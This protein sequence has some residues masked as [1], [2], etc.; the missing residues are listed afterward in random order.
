MNRPLIVSGVSSRLA[1]KLIPWPK[2]FFSLIP[3][4]STSPLVPKPA[5]KEISPDGRSSTSISI[6]LKL[7]SEPFWISVFT[8]LIIPKLF[9]LFIDL[10]NRISY[11]GSPSST[12]RLFLIT[13]SKV[14]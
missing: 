11:K 13:S 1:S 9:K 2:K 12:I 4:P 5:C 7:S 6:I 14:E 3:P 10:L 8:I